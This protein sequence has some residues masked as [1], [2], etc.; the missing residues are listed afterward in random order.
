MESSQILKHFN[1]M[2]SKIWT[3][4]EE[5]INIFI[6]T[7]YLPEVR[8]D[9]DICALQYVRLHDPV[10]GEAAVFG[11]TPNVTYGQ[12]NYRMIYLFCFLSSFFRQQPLHST[13]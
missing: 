5:M 9:R 6:D 8:I 13:Q 1:S 3:Y 11:V 10:H 12:K 7:L 4:K 2:N